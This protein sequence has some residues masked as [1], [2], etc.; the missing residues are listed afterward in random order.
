MKKIVF[1]VLLICFVYNTG[2]AQRDWVPFTSSVSAPPL[3][4]VLN[5]SNQFVKFNVTIPGVYR[6]IIDSGHGIFSRL[7]IPQ[8]G[9]LTLPGSPE[10]PFMSRLVAIPTC[11]SLTVS[12]VF[13]DSIEIE[14]IDVYPAPQIVTDIY[15]NSREVF[16]KTDSLYTLNEFILGKK[17]VE[18][19]N[20]SSI[21]SQKLAEIIGYPFKYNPFRHRM[22][23]YTHMEVTVTFINASDRVNCETGFFNNIL[24]KVTLNYTPGQIYKPSAPPSNTP[25]YVKWKTLNNPNEADTIRCDYLIIAEHMFFS[26]HSMAIQA[27][28]NYRAAYNGLDIAIVDISNIL[29]LDFS[30][31]DSS[32]DIN[33]QKIRNFIERVYDGSNALHTYDNRLAFVLLIGDSDPGNP[34]AIGIPPSSDASSGFTR[35]NDYYYSCIT[36][37]QNQDIYDTDGDLFLGRIVAS[38][39]TEMFN[40]VTKIK[41][42]EKEYTPEQWRRNI[43][44]A[45]GNPGV[46]GWEGIHKSFIQ[47]FAKYVF[48][49]IPSDFDTLSFDYIRHNDWAN[50]Y[51]DTL[52]SVGCGLI[53]HEGHGIINS[54]CG[55]GNLGCNN[56]PTDIPLNFLID[57]LNNPGK[58]P[59]VVSQSCLTGGFAGLPNNPCIGEKMTVYSPNKGYIAYI[60]NYGE[61]DL[62]DV[63][64]I[65]TYFFEWVPKCIFEDFST[66]LGECYLE[67]LFYT[68]HY[69]HYDL[70]YRKIL[71]G[72]PALNLMPQGFEITKGHN[73]ILNKKTIISSQI[74]VRDS[75]FLQLSPNDTIQ[76]I[77]QGRIIVDNGGTFVLGNGSCIMGENQNN[78]I[79]IYGSIKGSSDL[80]IPPEYPPI[81]NLILASQSSPQGSTYWKGI[82][83][84]NPNLKVEFQS[85]TISN[86]N[87]TGNLKKLI[88]SNQSSNSSTFVNSSLS[89]DGADIHIDS[90][91]FSNTS[92]HLSN[93]QRID[94]IE[95]SIENS[96]FNNAPAESVIEIDHYDYG[97]ISKCTIQESSGVGISLFYC[98]NQSSDFE[99]KD[100]NVQKQGNGQSTTWGVRIYRS[101]CK[102]SKN[103]IT[104]HDYGVACMNYSHVSLHGNESAT[105]NE[106]TQQ[107]KSN[108]QNQVRAIDISFPYYFH[109]NVIDKANSSVNPLIYYDFA[110]NVNPPPDPNTNPNIPFNIVR[111][112]KCNCLP[113]NPVLYPPGSYL[114]QQWCP[115]NSACIFTNLAQEAYEHAIIEIDSGHYSQAK[116][117][118]RQIIRN[119]PDD[120]FALEAAKKLIPLEHLSNGNFS[121]LKAFYDTTYNLNS[122]SLISLMTERLKTECDIET[123][124]YQS[125]I[126][127]YE[128]HI[129][130]PPT[131]SDSIYS[132]LDLEDL[133]ILMMADSSQ[134][135]A[136]FAT[137]GQLSAFTPKNAAQFYQTREQLIPLLFYNK[138]VN[139]STIKDNGSIPG[140]IELFPTYPNPCLNNAEI[141]YFLTENA[142]VAIKIYNTTGQLV[143][144]LPQNTLERG[145]HKNQIDMRA[146]SPGIYFISLLCNEKVVANQKIVKKN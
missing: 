127:W 92:I 53:F 121:E 83:F 66:L 93:N 137:Q 108:L 141:S 88:I 131:F 5:S 13:K 124:N 45:F 67:S 97:K 138:G 106:E 105:T 29:T 80:P 20:F 114:T 103:T 26:P 58:Y 34:N 116:S 81:K 6:S 85:P 86:C 68:M 119:F 76:F 55:S 28:A 128:S 33:A 84:Y 49:K 112:I 60:G 3:I 38:S 136:H 11:D 144:T 96:S 64:S 122:D 100:C 40:A 115:G 24:Q 145:R 72:D 65:P 109:N 36:H 99:V 130:D 35:P 61:A 56:A 90:S 46:S 57:S 63:H 73:V 30:I 77:D 146:F 140:H 16:Y 91:S 44:F 25:Q 104:G 18:C 54:W 120:I 79:S 143:L 62:F 31:P 89:I 69:G 1:A 22:K 95:A 123:G 134:R 37:I 74:F 19:S 59:F 2:N 4:R 133:Y 23:V 42:Y 8:C 17:D 48:D 111:N 51:I 52:N 78:E 39:E 113:A 15:G 110:I 129:M 9:R 87:V 14:N 107:I 71:F 12:V 82:R 142:K 7:E 126:N 94:S 27:L 75:A 32:Q 102:L 117:E 43:G 98:G 50:G 21:R 135:P 118:M 139:D 47:Q 70:D 125:A 132:I 41:Y 10:M 101:L